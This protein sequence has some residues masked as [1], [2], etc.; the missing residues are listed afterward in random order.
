ML[1][2]IKKIYFSIFFILISFISAAQTT[3]IPD[4]N[5]EQKLIDLGID[6]GVI[7]GSV[8]TSNI[9][10]IT[11]LDVSNSNI[12]NLTGIENFIA[13]EILNCNNN[14]L[15]NLDITNNTQ[16]L[17]LFCN[18]NLLTNLNVT[19]HPNLEVLWC[20]NNQISS[21]NISQNTNLRALR[22]E[23]NNLTSLDVSN[24]NG[25]VDFVC[26]NNQIISLNV[27]NISSLNEFRC[28]NNLLSNL[29][30]TNNTSL[31]NLSCEQNSLNNL[32]LT[33]NNR[34]ITLSCF[35]NQLT[36]LD[37]S[38]NPSLTNLNCADNNLCILNIKN[39]NN[40]NTI[41][42]YFSN[43]DNLNCVV[44]DNPNANHTRWFP[45]S[46]SN[47]VNTP[48]ACSNFVLVDVLDNFIGPSYTL[49]ILNNGN[50]FTE[51]GGNGIQLNTGDIISNSQTIY[52][53][54]ETVC[55]NNESNFNILISDA[56]Y[57]IPKYF[58]PN[59]DGNHDLWKVI[60]NKNTIN[61]ITI[62]DRYGKLL[63]FLLPNSPGWDGT[64]NGS[65]LSSDSYWYI[66]VLN[67]GE[68]VKGHFALKR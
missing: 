18:D 17:Q 68:A 57:Y 37:L 64:Y 49:P 43:N 6:S 63:K 55:S 65:L 66:V 58:T 60:D 50:Y 24:N 28:G 9:S 7:D 47:Y 8:L 4:V 10:G 15:A 59:N 51:S 5:F 42:I 41:D 35:G 30:I 21:L 13:L 36:E 52:I 27:S 48:D 53:Y 44:V 39:G 62:Y 2:A 26:E 22:C 20:F 32:N 61:N 23:N 67:T 31:T 45:T 19:L 12:S 54:N 1:E 3:A 16:L 33:N 40:S 14:L 38:Q 34:L 11:N 56:D 25:L 46:F 29:D